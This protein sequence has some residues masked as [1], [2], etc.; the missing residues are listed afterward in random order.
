M[1]MGLNATLIIVTDFIFG[2][3]SFIPPI[4]LLN[5]P[6]LLSFLQEFMIFRTITF[7]ITSLDG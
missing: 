7:H 5:K 2:A 3:V 4:V 6:Y 1:I